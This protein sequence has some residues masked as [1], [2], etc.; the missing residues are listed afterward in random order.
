MSRFG[1]YG[2]QGFVAE[3]YDV[4]PGYAARPDVDFYLAFSRAA[5]GKTLELG[6]G[7]GRIVI[8]TAT[9]G[10]P[11]VGLD[12]SEYMLAR[13][14]E[15]LANQAAAIQARVR[16]VRG[17]MSDFH[18]DEKFPLVTAPFRTF[19]HLI[20]VQEQLSCLRCVNKHMEMAGKLILDLFQTNL[21]Y[22]T[23]PD[24]TKETEDFSN[25]QVGDGRTL[26]RTHRI[27]GFH[28][29]EQYNDIEFIYY[30]THPDGRME[31]LVQAFPFRYFFRYEVEHL[32]A[33]T[34]F[35]TVDIFGKFDGSSFCD[36]SPEMIFIA[37][38]AHHLK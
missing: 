31:R 18:L 5:A 27:A 24:S 21:R 38:K 26:R 13:C 29:A 17:A 19:Q 28:P 30:V 34:G 10:C 36:D 20:D 32:L 22:I 2:D 25:V 1:G 4:V 14:R 12:V 11:V 23:N 37:E 6:C 33:R 3:F 9:A 8:P 7:T 15:K 35:N 16:L